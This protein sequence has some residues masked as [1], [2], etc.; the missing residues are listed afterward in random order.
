MG[1]RGKLTV[2]R[3][4]WELGHLA[5]PAILLLQAIPLDAWTLGVSPN[6]KLLSRAA[7]LAPRDVAVMC[8]VQM[9]GDARH[10]RDALAASSLGPPHRWL[11]LAIDIRS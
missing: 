4:R 10:G 8:W 3:L 1:A 5:S 9:R 11:W 6:R 2:N 7:R